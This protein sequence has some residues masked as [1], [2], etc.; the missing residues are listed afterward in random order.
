MNPTSRMNQDTNL[1]SSVVS[2]QFVHDEVNADVLGEEHCNDHGDEKQRLRVEDS[3]EDLSSLSTKKGNKPIDVVDKVIDAKI[4]SN[5]T[6]QIDTDITSNEGHDSS[7]QENHEESSRENHEE[8][9]NE[10]LEDDTYSYGVISNCNNPR[11]IIQPRMRSI[12][13]SLTRFDAFLKR[14]RLIEIQ[15]VKSLENLADSED[16]F[17]KEQDHS[18]RMIREM[19]EGEQVKNKM[20]SSQSHRSATYW[21]SL[22]PVAQTRHRFPV[23][24]L[25][26]ATRNIA[27]QHSIFA[28][29]LAYQRECSTK[30]LC[31]D[32]ARECNERLND[33][34]EWEIL[35]REQ[36]TKYKDSFLKMEKTQKQMEIRVAELQ[37]M[38]ECFQKATV[39][40]QSTSSSTTTNGNNSQNCVPDKGTPPED[41]VS[42]STMGQV[43]KVRETE[44]Q[45]REQNGSLT[46]DTVAKTTFASSE[47][48]DE[49]QTKEDS[50]S[51]DEPTENKIHSTMQSTNQNTAEEEENGDGTAM[52][53]SCTNSESSNEIPK[54]KSTEAVTTDNVED[55]NLTKRRRSTGILEYFRR[56]TAGSSTTV[57]H[58]NGK[59]TS[60]SS[61]QSSE[62]M[63]NTNRSSEGTRPLPQGSRNEGEGKINSLDG[64]SSAVVRN[65]SRI[66]SS[67]SQSLSPF[68][69]F[70]TS[71]SKSAISS[72]LPSKKTADGNTKT[73][74]SSSLPFLRLTSDGT[75]I[76][77]DT[78]DLSTRL[79]S[80]AIQQAEVHYSK[81][82]EC[83]R[84]WTKVRKAIAS[85]QK[86]L[87][88]GLQNMEL[89]S[90]E[91]LLIEMN[92]LIV[93]ETSL[94][95][96]Y[97]YDCQRLH[98]ATNAFCLHEKNLE[99]KTKKCEKKKGN[100]SLL[101]SNANV[102]DSLENPSGE[103]NEMVQFVQA[104]KEHIELRK[105]LP[106]PPRC[107]D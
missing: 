63:V 102:N 51:I 81:C 94:A 49:P 99:K 67:S 4:S 79:A 95:A 65:S 43:E 80:S 75:V 16:Q 98:E 54:G 14:R 33:L 48:D 61:P 26:T 69:S 106:K 87:L 42:D 92:K 20:T 93:N 60:S 84:E 76:S 31:T 83:Y 59:A 18:R 19:V 22:T 1:P 85:K 90:V 29:S 72:N 53:K 40:F 5:T 101:N 56:L 7:S 27:K 45:H 66:H 73:P 77:E 25:I 62:S 15:Y 6:E 39:D 107:E 86:D 64:D 103:V 23:L 104:V 34:H 97:Q 2:L 89:R 82:C 32:Y 24:G 70:A 100:E 68:R 52:N 74:T 3:V 13:E 9:S 38:Q 36:E 58:E 35:R 11:R 46:N 30:A 8:S 88:H 55:K 28:E 37:H 12:I 91:Q 50:Q 57:Y 44:I 21:D 96:N 78:L 105:R 47:H 17:W 71:F 41:G 10:N